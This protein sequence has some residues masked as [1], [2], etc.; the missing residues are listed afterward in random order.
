[1]VFLLVLRLKMLRFQ[2]LLQAVMLFF[3]GIDFVIF[4]VFQGNNDA[5]FCTIALMLV[6][7]DNYSFENSV[8][9]MMYQDKHQSVQ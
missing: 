8:C 4:L 3:S 6:S 1:M 2:I 5:L 7:C 9:V